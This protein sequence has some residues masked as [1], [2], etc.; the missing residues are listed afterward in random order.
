MFAELDPRIREF[1]RRSLRLIIGSG[2]PFLIGGAY[3]LARYTG[4]VRH[5]KDLDLFVRPADVDRTLARFAEAGYDTERSFPHW[6]AKVYDG[7]AFV[8]VIYRSGNGL[9]E[10][11]GGWFDHAV[12]DD[13]LGEPVRLC[14]AEEML[15][16]KGF[17]MERE[18]F[19]G[20][21][22]AHL[23]RARAD[24]LDWD[25]LLDRFGP[26]WR[27]LLGHLIL[28]GYIYPDERSRVP[29]RVLD[30]L[31]ARLAAEREEDRRHEQTRDGAPGGGLVCQGTFLSREQYLVDLNEWGY[32]DP[33]VGPRG[34]M[35]PD[36][37]AQWTDAIA[38]SQSEPHPVGPPGT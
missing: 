14:P 36:D 18:R 34:K 8:D 29:G 7:D 20:A 19:D 5:T 22:V 38:T 21:D 27:V 28:F 26:H 13:V 25:R 24:R 23:L 10:V 1:Y 4:V 9:A 31:L 17:V 15:W 6:L 35:T 2:I 32:R 16:S 12:D 37:V 33:R 30:D 11:D 3:A